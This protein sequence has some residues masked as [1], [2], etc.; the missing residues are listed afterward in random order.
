VTNFH[1]LWSESVDERG[2]ASPSGSHH[3]YDELVLCKRS[4]IRFMRGTTVLDLSVFLYFES[5]VLLLVTFST[6]FYC[7]KSGF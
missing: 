4:W 6:S 1:F 2:F 5:R 7:G 3:S